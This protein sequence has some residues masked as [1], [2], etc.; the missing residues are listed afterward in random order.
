MTQEKTTV[1][2][3]QNIDLLAK[4]ESRS[5]SSVNVTAFDCVNLHRG[6]NVMLGELDCAPWSIS[7]LVGMYAYQKKKRLFLYQTPSVL[8][9]GEPISPEALSQKACYLDSCHPLFRSKKTVKR[10]IEI[11]LKKTHQPL[12]VEQVRLMFAIDSNRFVRPLACVGN[13]RFRCMTA[14]GYA[15][16]KEIYCFPWFS[17]RMG[18][19]YDPHITELCGRLERYG[20]TALLP[21]SYQKWEKGEWKVIDEDPDT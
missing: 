3:L 1:L 11:G 12:S 6:V 17:Q 8:W 7:Y 2:S 13:S 21:T 16:R 15:W 14:I 5:N 10:L 19:Y 18:K 9:Q 4:C 20:L